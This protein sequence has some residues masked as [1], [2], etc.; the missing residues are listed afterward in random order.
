MSKG[1]LFWIVYIVVIAISFFVNWPLERRS[2][3]WIAILVLIGVLGWAVFGAVV[4]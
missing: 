1:L 3:S 2:A 4:Q